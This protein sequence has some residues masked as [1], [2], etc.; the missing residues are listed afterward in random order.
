MGIGRNGRAEVDEDEIEECEGEKVK[1]VSFFH[2][3][4]DD[5]MASGDDSPLLRQDIHK[6][7]DLEKK[8]EGSVVVEGCLATA[9][10]MESMRR[11]MMKKKWVNKNPLMMVIHLDAKKLL[12]TERFRR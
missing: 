12:L 7:F 10:K 5:F 2:Q 9:L 11:K 4:V 6:K 8:K 3:T 1:R